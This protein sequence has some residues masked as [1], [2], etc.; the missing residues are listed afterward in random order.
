MEDKVMERSPDQTQME[1]Q[2]IPRRKKGGLITIPF[3]I[4]NE[5]FEKMASYGLL[6]NIILYLMK[7]YHLSVAE[8]TNI[9]FIWSA[10]ISFAP[11]LGAFISDS[12]LGPFLTIGFGSIVS[13]LM[14]LLW[15][16]AMIPQSKPPPCIPS[17]QSCRSP[18]AGEMT[19]LL[20]SFALMSIGAGG[21]RPC[22]I[23]FGADQLDIRD[24]P[25]N[26][27]LKES[28]FGWYTASALLALLI[29]FTGIVYIQDHL[30]WKVGF[31]VPAILMFLSATMF[32]IGAPLY[33]K[34]KPTKRMLTSLVQVIVVAYQNRKLTLAP[35]NLS[36]CYYHDK[37]SKIVVPTDKLRFLNK[38]CIIRN[39]QQDIAPNASAINPW[40]L[41]TIGQV[42]ELK[43]LLRVLP[44][45]STG[46]M[47]SINNSQNSFPLLQA[48]SMDRH[49]S[50]NFEIPAA[51][52]GSSGFMIT[53]VI[54]IIPYDRVIL[55]MA[56]KIKHKP[57]RLDV[58]LRMG[59]GLFLS[60][61]AMVTSAIVE[62]I[63]RKKPIQ[64]GYL[65]NSNAVLDMSAMW[66]I[67][68]YC[69]LGLAEAFNGIAQSEFFYPPKK[70][71]KYSFFSALIRNG[72][73]HWAYGPSN[74]QATR[75]SGR[76][77]ALEE[78]E[79]LTNLGTRIHSDGIRLEEGEE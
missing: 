75:V 8:G 62:N 41:C 6:P 79:D 42:E 68:Q 22:S 45:W 11:L 44:L 32:F 14:I 50:K 55:P 15:S 54:W 66:L 31:G 53:M 37:D 18:T 49:I 61:M 13:L 12:Y 77:S 70:H 27:R 47:L 29:S 4:A 28:Y 63:R 26:E 43:A 17:T 57:V 1:N 59:I 56:S 64:E 71:V 72:L 69:L 16:T 76:G 38:A 3:I 58:K 5:A 74:E 78:E 2:E 48:S 24:N 10:A 25:K 40:R 73:C 65:N 33:T 36:E 52:F 9:L 7:D 51:S 60:S 21:V 39:P 20:S 19:H 67:P 23:A 35:P 46:I 34:Q 30:G